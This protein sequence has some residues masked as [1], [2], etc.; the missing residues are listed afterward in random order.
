MGTVRAR[1]GKGYEC[2]PRWSRELSSVG[3]QLKEWWDGE[4]TRLFAKQREQQLLLIYWDGL[5]SNKFP[6]VK[7]MIPK[8]S[9]S[10]TRLGPP[11]GHAHLVL[12]AVE[13]LCSWHHHPAQGIPALRFSSS[14]MI[15]LKGIHVL[16][17][18]LLLMKHKDGTQEKRKRR[19]K[20]KM[21]ANPIG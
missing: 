21:H 14:L 13:S 5:K 7:H 17:W 11:G 6:L 1:L 20:K 3:F 19:K 18:L 12:Q 10:C 16:E 8:D 15:G 9:L 4:R 2:A